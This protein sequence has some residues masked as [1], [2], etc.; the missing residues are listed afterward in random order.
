MLH[1]DALQQTAR[2]RATDRHEIVS[3]AG[4]L[5]NLKMLLRDTVTPIAVMAA[6]DAA[7]M[8][9]AAVA[10]AMAAA[11][12]ATALATAVTTAMAAAVA[13]VVT[14]VP[15][16][17]PLQAQAVHKLHSKPANVCSGCVWGRV[18]GQLLARVHSRFG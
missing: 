18:A 14:W 12:V 16:P 3:P 8:A 2:A 4:G 7:V 11:T 17:R 15:L 9:A 13:T 5:A 6:A 1:R 10:A